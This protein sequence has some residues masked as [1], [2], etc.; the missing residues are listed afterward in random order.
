FIICGQSGS[1]KTLICSIIANNLLLQQ[2]KAVLY[3]TWTDFI[4]RLKR[5]MMGDNTNQVSKYLDEIKSVEV[6]FIDELLKKYNETDLKYIIEIIN[7]RYTNNLKTIITSERTIEELIDIDEATFSR[8]IEKA[9]KYV[10]NVPKDKKKNYR[11]RN[12]C[13]E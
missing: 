12:I 9:D 11:L 2:K 1:G 10:I 6:L 4:S 5:D 7:H 8:V 13:K 3:I